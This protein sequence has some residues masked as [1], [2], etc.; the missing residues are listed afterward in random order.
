MSAHR[1]CAADELAPGERLFVELEGREIAVLNVDGL[2]VA[3]RNRCAH[4]GGPLGQGPITRTVVASEETGWEPK[5]LA[6]CVIRCPWH[7]LEYETT[8]GRVPCDRRWRVKVYETC[9]VDGWVEVSL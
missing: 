4:Q 8:S 5:V 7:A 3:V 6:G 9:V 2:F 1:V